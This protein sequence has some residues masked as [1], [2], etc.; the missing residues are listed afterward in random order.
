MYVSRHDSDL[1]L[2]GFDNS[3]TIGSDQS[4]F[5]LSHE[6]VL[7]LDHVLLGNSFRD[8]NHQWDF[9]IN[10]F[11]DSLPCHRWRDV[12]NAGVGSRGISCL[13]RNMQIFIKRCST[14]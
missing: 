7:D 6:S 1:A 12:D 14:V 5:V 10:G 4:G 2:S 9:R 3:G 8:T 13:E 11:Q